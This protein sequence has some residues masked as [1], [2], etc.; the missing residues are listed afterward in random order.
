MIAA[1]VFWLNFWLV[2][3]SE[4]PERRTAKIYIL[5]DYRPKP[6]DKKPNGSAAA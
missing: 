5:D 6:T 1:W 2:V 4:P 3:M